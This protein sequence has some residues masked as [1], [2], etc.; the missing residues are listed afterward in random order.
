[1]LALGGLARRGALGL[2]GILAAA[3]PVYALAVAGL[4]P[5]AKLERG[6]WL[7]RNVDEKAERAICVADPVTFI[8][9]EHQGA[10]CGYETLRSD[11]AGATV[12]YTCPGRGFGLTQ[13]RIEHS[14]LASIETQGLSGGRPFAYK[15]QA[16]KIGAC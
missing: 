12:R 15:V 6:R 8:R 7:L 4:P 11:A 3:M 2:A 1:M 10:A 13:V 16:R 9:L 5:L 14:R